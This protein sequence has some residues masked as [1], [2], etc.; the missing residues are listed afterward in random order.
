MSA[1]IQQKKEEIV[2]CVQRLFDRTQSPG[3]DTN[4]ERL[5]ELSME[6]VQLEDVLLLGRTR[7]GIIGPRLETPQQLIR[8]LLREGADRC[9]VCEGPATRYGTLALIRKSVV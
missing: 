1:D 5:R 4:L 2:A 9:C 3:D 8:E 7:G 6:L